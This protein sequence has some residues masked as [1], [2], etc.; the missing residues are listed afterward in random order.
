[1]ASLD[2]SRMLLKGVRRRANNANKPRV[3]GAPSFAVFKVGISKTT[4][5]CALSLVGDRVPQRPNS[6]HR[7]FHD[8]AC[9]Q[10]THAFGG[11]GR[12]QISWQQ[13]HHLRNMPDDHIQRKDEIARVALLPRFSIHPSFHRNPRPRVEFVTHDWTHRTK[14][15]EPLGSSPLAVFILQIARSYIVHTCVTEDVW[16]HIFLRMQAATA[17]SDDDSQLSFVV[18][19][20]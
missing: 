16:S 19:A 11:S 5:A 9:L 7:N 17:L 13:R 2:S 6:L 10:R 8:V 12:N 18:H 4:A 15:I 14:S 1:M 3:P 20:D